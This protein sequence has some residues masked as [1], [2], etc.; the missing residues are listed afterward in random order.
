VTAPRASGDTGARASE[1]AAAAHVDDRAEPIFQS[2]VERVRDIAIFTLDPLGTI[3][4][5]NI[6][7]AL[8]T[9]YR[10]SEVLGR[11]VSLLYPGGA[12]AKAGPSQRWTGTPGGRRFEDEVWIERRDGTHFWA[13]VSFS[14]LVDDAGTITG[15]A[16]IARDRSEQKEARQA[17]RRLTAVLE[18]TPDFVSFADLEG[19]I[20]YINPAGRAMLGIG[21]DEDVTRLTV[22]EVHPAWATGLLL[23]EVLPTTAEKGTWSGELALLTRDG[24]E[25]PVHQTLVSHRGPG[26]EIDFVSTIAR[27]ITERKRAEQRQELIIEASR[28]LAGSLDYRTTLQNAVEAV[29]PRLAD[30][31]AIAALEDEEIHWV[32]AW[33]HDAMGRERLGT[34]LGRR[35]PL[36]R[37]A[38]VGLDRAIA[39]EEP[40]LVTQISEPWLRAAVRTDEMREVVRTLGARS[41]MFVPLIARGR[42]LGAIAFLYS[43][44]GRRYGESDLEF[45]EELAGRAALYID[46]AR[47]FQAEQ[48]AVR[49]R[50]E[51]LSIVAHDLRN[52]L[53]RILMGAD[54]LLEISQGGELERK[55]LEIL[56][57]AASGMN[58][59]IQDLLEVARMESGRGLTIEP[60]RWRIAPLLAQACEMLEPAAEEKGLRLECVLPA[61]EDLAV[62]VDRDRF[63]QV[64]GNLIGNAVKFTDRGEI[65]VRTER[66]GEVVQ[67]SVADTGPGIAEEDLTHLFDRFWQARRSRRGGAGLGLAIT[68]GIVEAHGGRLWVESETGRGTMFY[69]TLPAG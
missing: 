21:K 57:R 7:A 50:D 13:D 23:R 68:R 36:D 62:K 18:G 16:V 29:V 14:A 20:L 2:V 52:P 65:R 24:R 39:S 44:S 47:L 28:R 33:H 8:L 40:E 66:R 22:S 61:E 63:L 58:R 34:L 10:R 60:Q 48:E 25:V 56:R 49:M 53:G 69:F 59:L 11:H 35:Q 27:D 5:W 51:V 31:C 12:H 43:D 55:Q 30:W 38:P 4:S 9:G 3:Q 64:M 46:N 17:Q 67:F 45:A 42:T 1:R 6:G 32:A 41:G 54:F 37:G 15:Y 19:R 26:R